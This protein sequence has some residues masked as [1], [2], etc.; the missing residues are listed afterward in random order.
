MIINL[1]P[2][3][4]N[5]VNSNKT[6]HISK[7][8]NNITIN[9]ELFDF[10]DLKEGCV[11]PLNSIS[12]DYITSEV[13]MVGGEISLTIKMPVGKNS[14]YGQRFPQPIHVTEDGEIDLP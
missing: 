11:L 10:S 6:L 2:T 3:R 13:K 5:K 9:D 7:R 12:S 14:T 8:G 4:P 1:T